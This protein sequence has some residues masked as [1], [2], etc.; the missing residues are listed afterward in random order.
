MPIFAEIVV[1]DVAN[2]PIKARINH[3][4]KFKGPFRNY[5]LFEDSVFNIAQPARIC[6]IILLT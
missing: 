3:S 6:K 5:R 1:S 4:I 2:A